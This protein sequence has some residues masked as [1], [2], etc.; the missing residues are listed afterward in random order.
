MT[1]VNFGL[2]HLID[3]DQ[4]CYRNLLETF[5][6]DKESHTDCESGSLKIVLT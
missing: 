3:L 4:W 1:V 6:S 5:K 2:S